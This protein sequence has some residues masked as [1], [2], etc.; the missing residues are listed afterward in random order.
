METTKE[1]VTII[2]WP[3]FAERV[4]AIPKIVVTGNTFYAIIKGNA[5]CC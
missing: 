5:C 1:A 3:S 4:H 2:F